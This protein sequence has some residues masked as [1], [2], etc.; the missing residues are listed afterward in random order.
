MRVGVAIIRFATT[1]HLAAALAWRWRNHVGGT[2]VRYN[3]RIIPGQLVKYQAIRHHLKKMRKALN[4]YVIQIDIS[5]C[6]I[7]TLI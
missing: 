4:L 1:R 2:R 5:I 6:Y 7:Q 3:F